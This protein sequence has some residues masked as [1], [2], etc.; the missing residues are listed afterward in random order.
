MSLFIRIKLKQS[1]S[2]FDLR[3]LEVINVQILN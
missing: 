1:N 2:R 3:P